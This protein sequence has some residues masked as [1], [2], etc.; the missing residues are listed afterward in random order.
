VN[1]RQIKKQVQQIAQRLITPAHQYFAATSQVHPDVIS[2]Y[3]TQV[4]MAVYD[5]MR[6]YLILDSSWPHRQRW[7]DRFSEEFAWAKRGGLLYGS[8]KLFWGHRPEVSREIT[9]LTFNAT[10]QLCPKHGVDYV[11]LCGASDN[12]KKY[13]SRKWCR[14][15]RRVITRR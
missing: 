2:R 10:L 12:L 15:R 14:L 7:L 9:G 13:S 4:E 6:L 5:L 8:S 3:E 1:R 11:F